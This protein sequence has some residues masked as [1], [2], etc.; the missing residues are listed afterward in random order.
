MSA[1]VSLSAKWVKTFPPLPVS[2]AIVKVV[3]LHDTFVSGD[4]NV[5]LASERA[6]FQLEFTQMY[7]FYQVL[8]P[9]WS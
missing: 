3:W 1:A 2:I 4:N 9:Q 8:Q 7:F 6:E 5:W